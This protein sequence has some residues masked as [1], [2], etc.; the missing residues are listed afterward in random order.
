[1]LDRFFF[2]SNSMSRLVAPV[3]LSITG[4]PPPVSIL[5]VSSHDCRNA[6]G[7]RLQTEISSTKST[8]SSL[9]C[10]SSFR[11]PLGSPQMSGFKWILAV[12]SGIEFSCKSFLAEEI[13]A[14]ADVGGF[15]EFPLI[16]PWSLVRIQ[17]GLFHTTPYLL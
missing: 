6:S 16:I 7:R 12:V 10:V 8:G 11:S 4:A 3:Y 14:S 13:G 9:A 17:A 2:F 15:W 5:A 1:M